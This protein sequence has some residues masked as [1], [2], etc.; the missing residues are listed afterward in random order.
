MM[1]LNNAVSE[2]FIVTLTEK[3]TIINP[4][5][6]FVFTNV[7]TKAQVKFF[8]LSDEDLSNSPVRYNEF[9]M[10][11]QN[12]F[13]GQ[14]AGQWQYEIYQTDNTL[15][16]VTTGLVLLENGKMLLQGTDLIIKGHA[17]QTTYKG[18]GG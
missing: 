7:T 4:V 5:F 1:L 18:Y 9:T 10:A 6:L 8:K 15:S 12:I 14:S 2:N 3:V 11:T 13:S 17:P 16:Q